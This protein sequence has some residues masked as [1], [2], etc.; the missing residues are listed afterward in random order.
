MKQVQNHSIA[1]TSFISPL[2]LNVDENFNALLEQKSGIDTLNESVFFP[3]PIL[4][5]VMDQGMIG[6]FRTQFNTKTRFDSMLLACADDM[7]Q[8]NT[9]DFS[10][11]DTLII[12]S[13]TKGNVELLAADADNHHANLNYSASLLQQHFKNPNPVLI[14]S[15]ACISGVSASIAAKRYLDTGIYRHVLVM[16]C[17]VVSRFVLSGFNSFHAISKSGCRP[18]DLHRDGV[19]LGEACGAILYS[20]AIESDISLMGG[21]ISND[22]NHISGPSRT[23]E[24]LAYCIKQTL[25]HGQ[26]NTEDIDF[27]SA[28][29]TATQYNDEMES[30]AIEAAGL[31]NVP[32]F[33]LKGHY[34]HTLGASGIIE[35]IVS[36]ECLR[37][38]MILPSLGFEEKGVSADIAVNQQLLTGKELM[39][40]LKTTSGFGGCN[41]ALLL[42]KNK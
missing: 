4:A 35:C 8:K 3:K 41:A 39:Y 30:K 15:N 10:G 2:G 16:G 23:G 9:V 31:N 42:R 24:E 6:R 28:H 1:D 19:V 14:V 25:H 22:A 18:F 36:I 26:V 13:T 38:N 20:A 37:R 21:I 32:V 40:A 12:L 7:L 27:V 29:G 11:A 34:G 33:S 5:S 17:D